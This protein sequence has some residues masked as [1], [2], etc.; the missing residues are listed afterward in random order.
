M[1]PERVVPQGFRTAL[2]HARI[3]VHLEK[4]QVWNRGGHSPTSRRDFS[5]HGPRENQT[6][7]MCGTRPW[8]ASTI[9]REDSRE[10]EE[11]R[12]KIAAGEGKHTAKFWAVQGSG[13]PGVRG[14]GR[15]MGTLNRSESKRDWAETSTAAVSGSPNRGLHRERNNARSPG[16][17]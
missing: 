1:A 4:T 17:S 13:N 12:M 8:T 9:A 10:R 6:R 15:K 2:E 5:Q 14:S 16:T 11:G 7:T 3:Q